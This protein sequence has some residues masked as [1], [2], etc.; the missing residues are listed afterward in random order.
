VTTKK[1]RQKLPSFRIAVVGSGAIGS[2]YGGKLAAGGRDVHFLMRGDLKEIRKRGLRIR[3]KDENLHVAKVSCYNS[4]AEIGVCD[5]VLIAVKSTSNGDLLELIPPLLDRHTILLTLQ[6]GLGNEEFLA[7]HFGAERVLAGLCFICLSRVSSTLIERF[8]YGQI[9]ISE[10]N[11]HPQPRTHDVASEF[12]RCGVASTVVDNLALERWRKL[13][14]NIPFNGLSVAAGGIDTASILADES[15]RLT[16]LALMDEV[17]LAANKCGHALSTTAA[18]EQMKRTETMGAYKPSTLI[19]FQA[20]RPLEIEAIWGEPL[21]RAA[22]AGAET[23]QLETLYR[24]L[25]MLDK[26]NRA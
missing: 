6:N 21:R 22:A 14:W 24:S 1:A 25:K 19:D 7:D 17:I 9:A 5:L 2:Y 3:G 18:F 23:P 12:K 4:T 20:G 10:F 26:R 13:V 15:L 16:A 11:L 8:D